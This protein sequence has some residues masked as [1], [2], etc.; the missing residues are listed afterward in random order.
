MYIFHILGFVISMLFLCNLSSI[1]SHLYGLAAHCLFDQCC[2]PTSFKARQV[3]VC[4]L[5][6]QISPVS[7]NSALI[8]HQWL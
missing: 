2:F 3:T 6:S 7:K 1:H 8:R 5:T 4:S